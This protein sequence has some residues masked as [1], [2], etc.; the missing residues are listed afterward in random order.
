MAFM[1]RVESD[2][3]RETRPW[4]TARNPGYMIVLR[5][6]KRQVGVEH[7]DPDKKNKI[8]K[9][10]RKRKVEESNRTRKA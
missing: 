3:I 8:D 7:L 10:E 2:T 5:T 4:V 6:S 1:N 9:L